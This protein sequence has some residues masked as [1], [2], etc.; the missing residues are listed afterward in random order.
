MN[1][2][3]FGAVLRSTMLAVSVIGLTLFAQP[4]L[5]SAQTTNGTA[6]AFNASGSLETLCSSQAGILN[7]IQTTVAGQGPAGNATSLGFALD[8]TTNLTNAAAVQEIAEIAWEYIYS[9][10]FPAVAKTLAA[11]TGNATAV[12][13]FYSSMGYLA[14]PNDTDVPA[15]SRDLVTS[16][17][18]LDLSQGPQ[19]ITV[20]T[21][22]SGRYYVVALLDLYTNVYASIGSSSNST[23]GSYLILGRGASPNATYSNFTSNYIIHAPTDISWVEARVLVFNN[24]DT[25]AANALLS[26]IT[27]SPYN[28]SGN[29][30][31]AV[32]KAAA[33][34]RSVNGSGFGLSSTQLVYLTTLARQPATWFNVSAAF[35]NT[36]PPGAGLGPLDTALAGLSSSAANGSNLTAT[37]FSLAYQ[38]ALQCIANQETGLETVTGWTFSNARGAYGDNYLLR[39]QTAYSALGSLSSSEEIVFVQNRDDQNRSLNCATGNNYTISFTLPIPAN[40]WWSLTLYSTAGLALV[41]NTIDRYSINEQTAG[42]MYSG[43]NNTTLPVVIAAQQPPTGSIQAANWLPAPRNGSFELELRLYEA[44][45]QVLAGNYSPPAVVRNAVTS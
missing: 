41:N 34:S 2:R 31:N 25:A 35:V 29:A 45:S 24:S 16:N 26:N 18:F 9:F 42:L 1:N 14:T 12:N 7:L 21:V 36:D 33:I 10:P 4:Q 19:V 13:T 44:Q 6:T 23:A 43:S 28:A 37:A 3:R 30:T 32:P 15:P 38:A 5:A 20:P 39:A 11:D 27:I 22:N 17:A 8:V 40:A